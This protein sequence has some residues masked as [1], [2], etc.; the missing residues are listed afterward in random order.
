[1]AQQLIN[2]GTI[3]NDRTGDT[4]R[5]SFNKTNQN[6]TELYGLNGANP[7]IYAAQESDFPV[8]DATTITLEAG[9]IYQYTASFTTAKRFVVEDGAKLTAFNFFSPTLT[10]S[11]TG[12]MF[13]GTD[14]SFS[15]NECRISCPNAQ[16]FNFNDTIGGTY[17]FIMDT[18]RIVAAS[19]FGTFNNLQA[20]QVLNSSSLSMGDGITLTGSSITVLSID[21]LF[22]LTAS[23]TFIGVDFG[24][25]ISTTIE[26][27]DF[28]AVGPAGS[29]GLKGAASSANTPAN[30]IAS[31]N[32]C[33][34]AAIGTPL[35]GLTS[36]DVRWRYKDNAG[37]SD[38]IIDSL[39]SLTSN[40]TNTVIAT[41]S[42]PVKVA[43]TWVVEDESIMTGDTTGR[44]TYNAESTNRLPVGA[45]LEVEP[46][47]GVNKLIKTYLAL[48]GSIIVNSGR[49]VKAD[50]SN[51]LNVAIT[52]QLDLAKDDYLELYVEN[53]TDSI[54][55]L[56]SG[57]VLRVN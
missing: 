34:F 15:I 43:G 21:K 5:N 54:D 27:D 57:A 12:S 49:Q 6:F 4:W 29:I 44:A 1:M 37:I 38:T 17:L 30:R 46:A 14:A 42:T 26:V 40:A 23:A 24:T 22:L 36:R 47:S 35:S 9:K 51:P 53:N 20:I 10:Y 41:V 11:G 52:W 28:I 7:V 13:T 39:L 48:N 56:V 8:Q 31:V 50:S 32:G 55:I 45:V 3:A 25:A 33:D 18:L 16:I 19:K 2:I